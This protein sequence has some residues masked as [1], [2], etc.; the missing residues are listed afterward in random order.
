MTD[1]SK[2]SSE[3]IASFA[4]LHLHA[5]VVFGGEPLEAP[6]KKQQKIRKWVRRQEKGM[7]HQLPEGVDALQCMKACA[8][9]ANTQEREKALLPLIR[10]IHGIAERAHTLIII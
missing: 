7:L 3:E 10:A 5:T 2:L 6:A 9:L 1:I 4:G 8:D